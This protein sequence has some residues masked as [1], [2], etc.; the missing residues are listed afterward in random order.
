VPLLEA[1]VSVSKQPN[2]E[3]VKM[4]IILQILGVAL[5][6][7]SIV[8]GV[9]LFDSHEGWLYKTSPIIG[10]L[11]FLIYGA[12][13]CSTLTSRKNGAEGAS[14]IGTI[15]TSEAVKFDLSKEPL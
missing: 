9:L 13:G 6:A 12:T 10:G 14:A 8:L 1:L 4:K 15:A 2:P 3:T 11:V 7:T 5:G